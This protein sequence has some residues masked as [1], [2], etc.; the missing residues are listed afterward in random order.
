MGDLEQ[1]TKDI[2]ELPE[3]AQKIIADIIE[4]FKKQYVTEKTGIS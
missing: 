2:Q 3:D 1:L 4:V